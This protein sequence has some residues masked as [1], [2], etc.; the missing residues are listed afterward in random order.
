MPIE[1][2]DL[3]R[4][5][6]RVGTVLEAAVAEGARLPALLLRIDFGRDLGVLRSSA[7][8]TRHDGGRL[9]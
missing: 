9:W 7:Q 6:I 8:L 2:E 1:Y 4:I 5:D 3:A